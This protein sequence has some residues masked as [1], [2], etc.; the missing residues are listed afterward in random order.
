MA[1][2]LA[3]I[4]DAVLA[5]PIAFAIGVVVGFLLSNRYRLVKRNGKEDP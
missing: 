2:A 5:A 4:P 3:E 1:F